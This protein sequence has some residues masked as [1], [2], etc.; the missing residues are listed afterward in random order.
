MIDVL[1]LFHIFL[2]QGCFV[3]R[4]Q[5]VEIKTYGRTE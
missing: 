4:D 1:R 3:P 5:H 2:L